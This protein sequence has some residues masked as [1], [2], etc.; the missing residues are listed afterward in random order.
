M[1]RR[2]SIFIIILLVHILAIFGPVGWYW[3]MHDEEKQREIV[4]KVELGGLDPSH[5]PEI[6]PPERRPV[7]G[8]AGETPPPA[9]PPEPP[10]PDNTAEQRRQEQ[11]RQRQQR[12]AEQRRQ[13]E[14]QRQ[15]REAEQR[16]QQ[17]QQRQ[18]QQAEQ[19]RRQEQ[20]RQR[21]QREAEQRRQQEQQRQRQQAE[22]R[23]RQ[24]Q[25]RQRQQ[26]AAE[27]R[28]RQE[29]ERQ[30]R[31]RESVHT[32]PNAGNF[33]PNK[34]YGGGTNT[35]QNT[36]TGNRDAGQARGEVDSRTPAGGATRDMEARRNAYI[37]QV[38]PIIQNRW[39]P[40]AG[41]FIT[42]ETAV[43][44]S[45]E[46]DTRGNFTGRIIR[47]SPNAAVNRSVEEML[48]TFSR[49]PVPPERIYFTVTLIHE[50]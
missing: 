3:L 4:F 17:E 37:R 23:R 9:P 8:T 34:R 18:R 36:R 29:Q 5:A 44:I 27:Q 43:Q 21:Q 39:Q 19:R 47:R 26:R 38:I 32:D 35:N 40:P 12:E 11:E 6:G 50:N 46:I 2:S 20:E 45:V 14:Q 30:R 28:R 31:E 7:T 42:R 25:E 13:Q 22:Q 16:R 41:V 33:D 48:R 24:E 15:Q 10:A 49:L 1:V